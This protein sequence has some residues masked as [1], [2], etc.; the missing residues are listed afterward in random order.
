[1]IPLAVSVGFQATIV[2]PSVEVVA[3]VVP[4][5]RLK[6]TVAPAPVASVL[7]VNVSVVLVPPFGVS[8]MLLAVPA[9]SERFAKVWA[10]VPVLLPRMLSVP[11]PRVRGELGES[12]FV[13]VERFAK[14]ATRLP[15]L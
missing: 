4:A 13:G 6:L 8:T 12:R 5:A 2:L 1:M 15:P 10:V 3:L 7:L 11:P 14:S 9:V